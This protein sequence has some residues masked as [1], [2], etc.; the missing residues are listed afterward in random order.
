MDSHYS[1]LCR[2]FE[3]IHHEYVTLQKVSRKLTIL[4]HNGAETQDTKLCGQLRRGECK[5]IVLDHDGNRCNDG[6]KE[7][8]SN[9]FRIEHLTRTHD[10]YHKAFM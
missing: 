8:P 9:D 4:S 1:L 3:L 7:E 2:R 10:I 6:D 5:E